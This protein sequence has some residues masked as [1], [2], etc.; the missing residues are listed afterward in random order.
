MKSKLEKSLTGL[1]N[2]FMNLLVL[3]V[4]L[5]DYVAIHYNPE[6]QYIPTGEAIKAFKFL[7]E[8]TLVKTLRDRS[9]VAGFLDKNAD[10]WTVDTD[11]LGGLYQEIRKTPFHQLLMGE[12]QFDAGTYYSSVFAHL[13]ND[14]TD[15]D[16]FMENHSFSWNDDRIP[17]AKNLIA[18]LEKIEKGEE[19]SIPALSNDLEEDLEFAFNLYEKTADNQEELTNILVKN[20]PG[21]D[22]DRITR[23]DHVLMQMAVAEFLYFPYVPV[24]VTINEYLELAKNYSTPK[25]SKFINGTLDK[26]KDELTQSGAI[27]K[28][29]RGLLG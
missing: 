2:T 10:I 27:Q 11:F 28:K 9:E 8:N 21:W 13:L 17:V 1:E 29:G 5:A 23:S 19:W 14:S 6:D 25:S 16:E 26:V 18:T 7:T 3:P 4:Q 15:F 20:T 22:K 12:Q 24:K